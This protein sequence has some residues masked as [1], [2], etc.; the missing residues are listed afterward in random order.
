MK[1]D[2]EQYCDNIDCRLLIK[3]NG[4]SRAPTLEERI[5]AAFNA[6]ARHVIKVFGIVDKAPNYKYRRVHKDG[7]LQWEK[8]SECP[9][10]EGRGL[11][12]DECNATSGDLETCP[13]QKSLD[14]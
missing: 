14:K 4:V 3:E 9:L 11:I 13:C 10:C 2:A 7:V 12:P 8:L 1:T 6:G 5:V